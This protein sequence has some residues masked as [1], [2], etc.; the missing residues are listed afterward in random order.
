MEQEFENWLIET[1]NLTRPD[2][3]SSTINTISND[4]IYE[5]LISGSLYN[6]SDFVLLESLMNKYFKI[7]RYATKNKTG[8]NMYSSAFK[9]YINFRKQG[10]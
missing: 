8:N 5:N 7:I 3:Y 6:I 1:R 10:N 9:H 2:K 4:L